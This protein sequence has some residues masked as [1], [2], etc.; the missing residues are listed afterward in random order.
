MICLF[1]FTL[2]S[3]PCLN[4]TLEGKRKKYKSVLCLWLATGGDV[5][6]GGGIEEEEEDEWR[7]M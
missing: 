6:G 2:G 3:A 7:D 5:R 1:C 4:M